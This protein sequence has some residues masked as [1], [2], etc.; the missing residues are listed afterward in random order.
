M[1]Q[2]FG[3]EQIDEDLLG[4]AVSIGNFD[5]LHLGHRKLLAELLSAARRHNAPAI[6]VTFDPFPASVVSPRLAGAPLMPLGERL[7]GLRTFGVD[8]VVVVRPD[9][10]FLSMDARSFAERVLVETMRAVAVV[11]GRDW[12]FGRG[13]EGD[14]ERLGRLGR[15]LDFE[16]VAV[17]P[18]EISIRGG[19]PVKV[20]SRTVRWLLAAGEVQQ[21]ARL[22]ARPYRLF[23]R[24]VRGAGVGRRI[25]FPTANLA[26]ER[27]MLPADG[28]YA[29]RCLVG[30]E[31]HPA[32]VHVGPA[33]TFERLQRTVEVHLL[34]G[35]GRL[36]GAALAVDFLVRLR[37]LQKFDSAEALARQIEQDVRQAAEC[38]REA[39]E[40]HR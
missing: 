1:R 21:A 7:R 4:A 28:V 36:E 20:S 38:L 22:L 18:V 31:L 29:G 10:S 37:D 30:D 14:V 16:V 2:F 13:R 19:R 15:R 12:R 8:A 17:E 27:Q 26:V 25:G 40:A 33:P 11:E 32:V 35:Q 3:F 5:G 24:V 23:G 6:V 39:Q 34:A 9:R